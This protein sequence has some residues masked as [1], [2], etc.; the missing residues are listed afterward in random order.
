MAYWYWS[1]ETGDPGTGRNKPDIWPED[2]ER[3]NA[4]SWAMAGHI[5]TGRWQEMTYLIVI[6][7]DIGF[8][9]GCVLEY[10]LLRKLK[11][12]REVGSWCLSMKWSDFSGPSIIL[13][14]LIFHVGLYLTL[15][16]LCGKKSTV[17]R[18]KW[19]RYITKLCN[20]HDAENIMTKVTDP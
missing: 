12:I 2:Q 19:N 6:G 8:G 16:S 1:P 15:K 18:I 20:A 4:C 17:R 7:F 13:L 10:M 5:G 14:M 9:L 11:M 3:N